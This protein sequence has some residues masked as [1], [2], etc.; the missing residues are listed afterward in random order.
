[1]NTYADKI[2]NA[3]SNAVA[4]NL[5]VRRDNVIQRAG[6]DYEG[7]SPEKK[8]MNNIL[9]D[10]DLIAELGERF[11]NVYDEEHKKNERIDLINE[12]IPKVPIQK[13]TEAVVKYQSEGLMVVWKHILLNSTNKEIA[14]TLIGGR[15][16]LWKLLN[17]LGE[18]TEAKVFR[19]FKLEGGP[20]VA[21]KFFKGN[22]E[23]YEDAFN[24]E[25]DAYKLLAQFEIEN[26]PIP[27][28]PKMHDYN[29]YMKGVIMDYVPGYRVD[30]LEDELKAE[31]KANKPQGG[32]V[33]LTSTL[34]VEETVGRMKTKKEEALTETRKALAERGL[35]LSDIQN[36]NII[37]DP[38]KD[39]IT[40]I[41]ISFV[42]IGE[43]KQEDIQNDDKMES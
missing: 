32:I 18:G 42:P 19:G 41:D 1:M 37:Y 15:N 43:K 36:R 8:Q 35:A 24:N 23:L 10:W 27:N 30:L 16:K 12:Q 3:G 20:L 17:M 29:T 28:V 21:M 25:V 26:R 33:S 14:G 31:K 7:A 6:P 5:N 39:K 40:F 2:H 9:Q 13:I 4:N 34:D 22:S 11:P 38:V